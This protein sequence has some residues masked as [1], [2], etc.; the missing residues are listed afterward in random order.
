MT[1]NKELVRADF[2]KAADNYERYAILQKHV[3]E[4]LI[5]FGW[6]YLPQSGL[7]L[8]VGSGTGFIK[9]MLKSANI[10]QLDISEKMCRK[11]SKFGPA[12]VGDMESIPMQDSS[13]DGVISSLTLQW[14]DNIEATLKEIH[15]VL[16]PRG[17]FVLS[18]LGF[19][20][21]QELKS[22]FRIMDPYAHV[23]DFTDPDKLEE[24]ASK[25]GF[26]QISIS[27]ELEIKEYDNVRELMDTI[28]RIGA[29]NKRRERKKALTGRDYFSKMNEIY[30]SSFGH[31]VKIP[32]TWEVLYLKGE[33]R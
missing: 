24:I 22:I 28:K 29:G 10:V 21:L 4:Q 27:S 9:Q 31:G 32:A 23:N 6:Q 11:C 20:T 17:T 14:S 5:K 26:H 1:L 13:V 33:K 25:T 3:A 8:D 7:L 18:T 2:D 30:H 12:I 19:H 16:K 15:R